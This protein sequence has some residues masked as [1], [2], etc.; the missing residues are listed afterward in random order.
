MLSFWVF[1]FIAPAKAEPLLNDTASNA[2]LVLAISLHN[3][4]GP[5]EYR[6]ANSQKFVQQK[7]KHS[8]QQ[9]EAMMR[10]KR[11]YNAKNY[12]E[13][14]MASYSGNLWAMNAKP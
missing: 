14:K 8:Q 12:N 7:Y 6:P 11:D 9:R 3:Q 4:H 2:G 13:R 1:L 5:V 10:A